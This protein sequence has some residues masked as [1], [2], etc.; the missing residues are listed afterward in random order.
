[1]GSRR[2]RGRLEKLQAEMS[3]HQIAVRQYDGT[4][5][6]FPKSVWKE[7][8]QSAWS[9]PELCASGMSEEDALKC[10]HPLVIAA[11]NSPDQKWAAFRPLRVVARGENGEFVD[12]TAQKREL[13]NYAHAGGPDAI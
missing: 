12:V 2:I 1:M 3:P 4:T 9:Y 8:I 11:L 6:V 5:Q 13:V 7:A 10:M